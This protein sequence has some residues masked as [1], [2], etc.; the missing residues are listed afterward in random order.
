MSLYHPFFIPGTHPHRNKRVKD[1]V[2]DA[3]TVSVISSDDA[4]HDQKRVGG[5][6]SNTDLQRRLTVR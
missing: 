2:S 3:M 6:D 1:I 4:K 5:D